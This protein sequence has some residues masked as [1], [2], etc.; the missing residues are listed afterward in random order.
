ML[1]G[2]IREYATHNGCHA[3][4][5]IPPS[6]IHIAHAVVC[7]LLVSPSVGALELSE[8]VFPKGV[9]CCIQYI[10]KLLKSVTL[11]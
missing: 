10:D 5:M 9:M 1:T 6:A 4:R 7:L 3:A 8:R 11:N 2:L